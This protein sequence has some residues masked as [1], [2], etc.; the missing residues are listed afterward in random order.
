MPQFHDSTQHYHTT[1]TSANEHSHNDR[2]G[3]SAPC[4]LH[5]KYLINPT[6]CLPSLLHKEQADRHS[7][8]SGETHLLH[9]S[10]SPRLRVT[11]DTNTVHFLVSGLSLA[12]MT[13]TQLPPNTARTQVTQAEPPSVA[14]NRPAPKR[15]QRQRKNHS[16]SMPQ[17]DGSVSDSVTN[18]RAS[19]RSQNMSKPRQQS[20]AMVVPPNE[21]TNTNMSKAN[22]HK[23]RHA[24]VGNTLIPATP[25]KEQAYAGPTFQASPAPSSLPVPKFF[26]RS[27]PNVAAHQSLEARMA[28]D[29]AEHSSPE[30]DTATPPPRA[31]QQ[32]PLDIFFNADRAEREKRMLSPE[33]A[34]RPPPPAT[35]P[36]NPFQQSGKGIFLRELDGDDGPMI[37][38]KSLPPT[39]R[40]SPPHR[41]SSTPGVRQPETISEGERDAYTKNLKDLQD[42][43]L[44]NV[45]GTPPPNHTPFNT[46]RPHTSARPISN[47]FETPSPFHRSAS[48]PSTPS[49][50]PHYSLH[51]G[52]RNLSPLFKAAARSE[53]PPRGPSS[54]RQEL[55]PDATR[56]PQID[57]NSFSRS[58][59][60]YTIRNNSDPAPPPVSVDV[61]PQA[62]P[63]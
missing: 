26:S 28:G 13:D 62:S 41:A 5:L 7:T 17:I 55:A 31:T 54:L 48:G 23:P 11:C 40:P 43:L 25:F 15:N 3:S 8:F 9:D 10:E 20:A 1:S 34:A 38:P 2:Q 52:N 12:A 29:K 18:P 32:S 42:L 51:Y 37:S 50:Q 14:H 63:R 59:L 19:P 46:Q 58:Y 30:S 24:S 6:K 44:N 39:N 53:T 49:P 27:V 45:N 22:G 21:N 61:Q 36:R 35:E 57:P 4:T 47:T 60:D 33:T 56:A 16:H